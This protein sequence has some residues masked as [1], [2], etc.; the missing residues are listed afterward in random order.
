MISRTPPSNM[1]APV[2]TLQ[3]QPPPQPGQ[4][5]TAQD[6][7]KWVHFA[8]LMARSRGAREV[9]GP[10]RHTAAPISG[11]ARVS[12]RDFGRRAGRGREK[13]RFVLA[14]P[15]VALQI[16]LPIPSRTAPDCSCTVLTW[17]TSKPCHCLSTGYPGG[18]T[19]QQVA[20]VVGRAVAVAVAGELCR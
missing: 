1:A 14:C 9:A 2:P 5:P 13:S 4:P 8:E 15:E 20:D 16:G 6:V 3:L 10:A 12:G 7:A 17:S 11:G 19:D 18:P